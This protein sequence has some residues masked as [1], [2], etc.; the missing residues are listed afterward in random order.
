M[1]S[2]TGSSLASLSFAAVLHRRCLGFLDLLAHLPHRPLVLGL[3]GLDIGL[4]C[5]EVLQ[6]RNLE[7]LVQCVALCRTR[8]VLQ[9]GSLAGAR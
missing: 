9:T 6:Q 1:E 4:V 5:V 8:R 2:H 3:A 7:L